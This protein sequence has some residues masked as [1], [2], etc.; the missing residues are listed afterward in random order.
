MLC[1]ILK[2]LCHNSAALSERQIKKCSIRCALPSH[3]SLAQ[4]QLHQ[5][6]GRLVRLVPGEHFA[7]AFGFTLLLPCLVRTAG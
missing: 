3:C 2:V 1:C 6:F 4:L 7:A 5:F